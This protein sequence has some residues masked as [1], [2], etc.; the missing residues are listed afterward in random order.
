MSG[1]FGT[2]NPNTLTTSVSGLQVQSSI[3][4]AAIPLAFGTCLGVGN[5]ILVG[6]FVQTAG[7]GTGG[8]GGGKGGGSGGKGGSSS[9]DYQAAVVI[10]LCDGTTSGTGTVWMNKSVGDATGFGFAI[11]DGGYGQAPWSYTTQNPPQESL[12][13]SGITYAAHVALDLGSSGQL[14][15]LQ[16]VIEGLF[17]ATAPNGVDADSSLVAAAL[18]TH[19]DWGLGFPSNRVGQVQKLTETHTVPSSG[20]YTVSVGASAG[21]ILGYNLCVTYP[22]NPQPLTCVASS[23]QQGQYSFAFTGSAGAATY[24]F[25]AADAGKQVTIECSGNTGAFTLYQQWVNAAGLWISPYYSDQEQASQ[26]LQ[27]IATLTY[28]DFVW[29]GAG[30]LTLVPRGPAA[31]NGNGWSYTPPGASPLF[32]LDDD[33]YLPNTNTSTASSSMNDDPVILTL[34]R[35]SDQINDIQLECLD[36]NNSFQPT[37]V[38]VTDQALIDSFVRRS[39]GKQDAHIFTDVGACNTS[40][41]LQLQDQYIRI[42]VSITLDERYSMLEPADI[43]NLADP[44]I[45]PDLPNNQAPFRIKTITENDDST[46]SIS[47][48]MYPGTTAQA[49]QFTLNTGQGYGSNYNAPAPSIA[50][51]IIWEPTYQ[52]AGA[53]AIWIALCGSASNWGGCRIYA[54][55][56]G[57]SYQELQG[58]PFVGP[59]AP[60]G[61]LTAELQSIAQSS[62]GNTIDTTNTLS[63]DIAESGQELISGSQA[64]MLN[65][66]TL[67][68]VD[69]EYIAFETATLGAEAGLYSLTTLNRGLY[70]SEID[71]HLPGTSFVRLSGD[72]FTTTFTPDRVGQKVYFKFLSFNIYGGGQQQLSDVPVYTYVVQGTALMSPLGNVTGLQQT[73]DTN[74]A[75]EMSW[76]A[77]TDAIRTV[78][79]EIRFGDT[80]QFAM[81]VARTSNTSFIVP[82]DGTYWIAAHYRTPQGVDVYSAEWSSIDVTIPIG[83]QL[84]I[85]TWNSEDYWGLALGDYV[86]FVSFLASPPGGA[87]IPP[88]PL[89]IVGPYQAFGS[90]MVEWGAPGY[91]IGYLPGVYLALDDSGDVLALTDF[92]N[93]PNILFFG[94]VQPSGSYM[95]SVLRYSGSSPTNGE[96]NPLGGLPV[97]TNI[98]ATFSVGFSGVPVFDNFL[99]IPNVLADPDVLQWTLC[100]QAGFTIEWGTSTSITTPPSSWLPWTPGKA[101][102]LPAMSYLFWQVT[103]F[104]SNPSV[105]PQLSKLDYR[106]YGVEQVQ[107]GYG[108]A[109]N[110]SA[111]L[112]ATPDVALTANP[113]SIINVFEIEGPPTVSW[114]CTDAQA[115]DVVSVVWSSQTISTIPGIEY[116][117]FTFRATNSGSYVLR[118]FNWEIVGY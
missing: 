89:L 52:L 9:A 113:Q 51:P 19:P 14:P 95:P 73:V 67:C 94:G 76:T 28:A 114:V 44:V 59:S 98:A 75:V 10:A 47:G 35:P 105:Q 42:D 103:L 13:Y 53:E 12:P 27:E 93:E 48:E 50:P 11:F 79:Y 88:S 31:V 85:E 22:G 115:G 54:S 21:L 6:D 109:S 43:V 117:G 99:T 39:S 46:L 97:D 8:K 116:T 71:A 4:G 2:S 74:N 58:S 104:T 23:P 86:P 90:S 92:L 69:G 80:F 96:G 5:L 102:P 84:L 82:S 3:Y 29:T 37:I 20:P 40:A 62:I 91:P 34:S 16:W 112:P 38:E 1:L 17:W 68:Y 118:H 83:L 24:T 63:V 77:V 101:I 108:Q 70:G 87:E 41:M 7:S 55:S 32:D 56:D 60:M 66:N 65:A 111:S 106:L 30:V 45:F 25:S 64:D 15:N 61:T 100:Q 36:R 72:Y 18:L 78:D 107:K 33:D 110:T 49:P 81:F 26:L 57:V